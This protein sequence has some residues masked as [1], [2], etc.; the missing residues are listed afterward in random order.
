M[1]VPHELLRSLHEET[2][3]ARGGLVP[4]EVYH[5]GLSSWFSA[6]MRPRCFEDHL[7]HVYMKTMVFEVLVHKGNTHRKPYRVERMLRDPA[8]PDNSYVPAGDSERQHFATLNQALNFIEAKLG[9]LI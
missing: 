2:I 6:I 3:A 4:I 7:R 8:D 5:E 1:S 9:R